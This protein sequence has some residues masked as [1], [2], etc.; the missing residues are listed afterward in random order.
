[1]E[2]NNMTLDDAIAHCDEVAGACDTGCR[3]EHKQL[4][5]WLRELKDR[6]RYKGGNVAAMREALGKIRAELWNNTVIA[7]KKKFALY[8]IADHA[9]AAPP[10]QCDMGTIGEQYNR[11][12]EFCASHYQEYTVGHCS[13]CPFSEPTCK[14]AWAQMPF[15]KGHTK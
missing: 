8:E 5:D 6:R 7:G 3:R 15:E 14:F 9:L 11:F 4:A 2:A 13:K 12:D 1:M 10:R